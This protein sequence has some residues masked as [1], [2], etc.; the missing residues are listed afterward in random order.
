MITETGALV[1]KTPNL[2]SSL[3]GLIYQ[4][5]RDCNVTLYL[6]LGTTT[7]IFPDKLKRK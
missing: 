5:A 7:S 1:L 6:K 4:T 2:N 3:L